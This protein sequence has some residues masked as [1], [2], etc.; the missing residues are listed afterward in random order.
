MVQLP[1]YLERLLAGGKDVALVLLPLLND[2]RQAR[3][4]PSLS[5][6]TLVLLNAGSVR[7]P[8]AEPRGARRRRPEVGRG[9]EKVAQ[10][11]R[12]AFQTALLGWIKGADVARHLDELLRVSTGL[13]RAAATE[14][15]KQL[16]TVL[17]AVLTA[18]RTRRPR[19]DASRSSA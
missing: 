9:F 3:D 11:L 2:L 10:R 6:G 19:G 15:V 13:E 16:W 7:A 14:Q 8:L 17:T 5:E 12:P 18:I 1:A 4:K